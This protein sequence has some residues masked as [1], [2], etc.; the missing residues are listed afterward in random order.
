[1]TGGT[2]L[3]GRELGKAL[4]RRGHSLVVLTRNPESSKLKTPYPHT[5]V[6]WDG[7]KSPLDSQFFKDVDGV[8]HLAGLGIADQR[9]STKYKKRLED[10]RILATQNLLQ[11]APQNLKFFI[12]SS[13]IGYYPTSDSPLKEDQKPAEHFFGQLCKNWE[14]EAYKFLDPKHVRISHIRTGVVF[15]PQGGALE[16]MLPPLRTGLG[17]PLGNGS[18]WMSWIDIE[19]IV[20]IYVFVLENNLMGPFNGVAPFPVTNKSLTQKIGQLIKRPVLLPVPQLALSVV[21]GEV[22]KFLTLSQNISSEKIQKSGYKFKFEKI[23]E[24]LE[25][26]IPKL[27]LG[28][29][30][31]VSEQYVYEP[32]EK[33]FPFFSNA[34]NL[35]KITPPSFQFKVVSKSTDEIKVGTL[36][37]YKLK[38]DGLIPARWQTLITE[39]NPPYQFSDLQKKG[40]YKKWHHTHKFETL[41]E[42]VLMTDQ[43]DYSLPLGWLGWLVAGWKVKRDI[44]NIFNYRTKVLDQIFKK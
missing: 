11:N 2:G 26:N 33:V 8:I 16:Q 28:E 3:I 36:I 19:D 22:A 43:V 38:I 27:K 5:P 32:L 18:Q 44:F 31:Y 7:E 10:S 25:K 40:P 14:A 21:L 6:Y 37:N 1:M 42:G 12:G 23:D 34:N 35:E 20:G 4:V 39:W 30:R 9:W 29:T 24:C 13:A 15:G 17:G 41:G